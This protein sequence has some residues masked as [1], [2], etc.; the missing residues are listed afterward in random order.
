VAGEIVEGK[1]TLI[2]HNGREFELARGHSAELTVGLSTPSEGSSF[3]VRKLEIRDDA[4]VLHLGKKAGDHGLGSFGNAPG[5]IRGY[6][7]PSD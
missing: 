7:F 5:E 4:V 6:P 1:R 3:G 2:E